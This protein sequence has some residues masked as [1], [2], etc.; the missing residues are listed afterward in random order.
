M[1][2]V[3]QPIWNR[4]AAIGGP[5]HRIGPIGPR[6][7]G[8]KRNSVVQAYR[9][10]RFYYARQIR[11]A[12]EVSGPIYTARTPGWVSRTAGSAC[13]RRTKSAGPVAAGSSSRAVYIDWYSTTKSTKVVYR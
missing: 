4:Y 1:W 3:Y 8:A 13:R 5:N 11:L 6:V 2:E 9:G 7:A 10:G 12:R